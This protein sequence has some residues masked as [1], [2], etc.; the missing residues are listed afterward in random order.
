MSNCNTGREGGLKALA[1]VMQ[2]HLYG[3]RIHCFGGCWPNHRHLQYGF[4]SSSGWEGVNC[5]LPKWLEIRSE[6]GILGFC[7]FN[8]D[9][10]NID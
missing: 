5:K 3:Y 7:E 2:N 6:Y 8:S 1:K 9:I 10:H 4:T